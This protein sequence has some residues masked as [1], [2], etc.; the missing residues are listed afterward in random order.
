MRFQ[1]PVQLINYVSRKGCRKNVAV[2]VNRLNMSDIGRGAAGRLLELPNPDSSLSEKKEDVVIVEDSETQSEGSIEMD[3]EPNMSTT[4]LASSQ[5]SDTVSSVT[6]KNGVMVNVALSERMPAT[7][8]HSSLLLRNGARVVKKASTLDG[9]PQGCSLKKSSKSLKTQKKATREVAAM[10]NLSLVANPIRDTDTV[11]LPS[12]P[13][14]S[15]PL[16]EHSY[17]SQSHSTFSLG[18]GSHSTPYSNYGSS[19]YFSSHSAKKGVADKSTS[20][21]MSFRNGNSNGLNGYA[22]PEVVALRTGVRKVE[23][24]RDK[25]VMTAA[26][27]KEPRR[28]KGI[29][30]GKN[31]RAAHQHQNHSSGVGKQ[32]TRSFLVSY[33][34]ELFDNLPYYRD[35]LNSKAA[36]LTLPA[37]KG[38]NGKNKSSVQKQKRR[39][40]RD[41]S[42]DQLSVSESEDASNSS[43]DSSSP[44]P[45]SYPWLCSSTRKITQ[46][47]LF[48]SPMPSSSKKR[49]GAALSGGLAQRERDCRSHSRKRKKDCS[50]SADVLPLVNLQL[51]HKHPKLLAKFP[52][53]VT[54]VSAE[55]VAEEKSPTTE[56]NEKVPTAQKRGKNPMVQKNGK[57]TPVTEMNGATPAT[58]VSGKEM[59]I[60]EKSRKKIRVEKSGKVASITEKSGKATSITEKSAKATSITE[61]S[62]KATCIAEKSGKAT[63][64]TEKSGKATSITEKSGKATCIAEKSGKAT[65]I[66]EKSGK[67]T[68][69]AEKSGKATSITEKSG[70]ATST[71]E[72][73]GKTKT[74]T[75]SEGDKASV[76]YNCMNTE[77]VVTVRE[78]MGGC[79]DGQQP[80]LSMTSSPEQ[81]VADHKPVSKSFFT[82]VLIVFDSR[83][84]CL[85]NEGQYAL[86]M[87]KRTNRNESLSTFEPLSWSTMFVDCKSS[88]VN[89]QCPN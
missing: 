59:P 71:T 12:C 54:A 6:C 65:S 48:S 2:S 46:V 73:S 24:Q 58:E 1:A 77:E 4:F 17:C 62:G 80:G 67:A 23:P 82:S 42:K 26:V 7:I 43:Q 79:R 53:R 56:K 70:K 32:G 86:P 8:P 3:I 47:S 49:V 50:D 22:L 35:S 41:M 45:T 38:V 81:A 28:H 33:S 44:V 16:H 15:S 74:M 36:S 87:R 83:G 55:K 61:K 78:D 37:S 34:K 60:N 64:I 19:N 9:I 13:P 5:L 39:I 51:T 66:T 18:N 29:S 25:V 84:E 72:K 69:I 57:T 31:E 27:D 85:V 76:S 21:K 30:M 68:C 89:N 63:S 10:A 11:S 75:E 14:T 40:V 52:P 20:P 88:K